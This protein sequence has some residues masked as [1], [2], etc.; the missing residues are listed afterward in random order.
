M[1]R[2]NFNI[3][4]D[5]LK[6]DRIFSSNRNFESDFD[7]ALAK[8]DEYAKQFLSCYAYHNLWLM[9]MRQ[10]HKLQFKS[11]DGSLSYIVW[12]VGERETKNNSTTIH[13]GNHVDVTFR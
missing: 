8:Y 11:T 6:N 7:G 5:I 10:S 2:Q 9:T 12:P 4:S 1:E 13:K 3:K